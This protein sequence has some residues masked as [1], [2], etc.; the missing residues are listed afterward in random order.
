[1]KNSVAFSLVI[2]ALMIAA[3]L[4]MIYLDRQGVIPAS[5]EEIS[6]RTMGVLM[7]LLL[8]AYANMMPKKMKPL[9]ETQCD[10]GR[11]Q[12]AR[13]FSGKAIV[14]GGALWV[15]AWIAAPFDLANPLAMIAVGGALLLTLAYCVARRSVS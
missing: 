6:A 13:R 3:P 14:L 15:V 2:A 1:M 12:G 9:A 11:E 8:I 7:G 4:V 5:G 10:P